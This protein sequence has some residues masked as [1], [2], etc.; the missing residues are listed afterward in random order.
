[1]PDCIIEPVSPAQ[2]AVGRKGV[3]GYKEVLIRNYEL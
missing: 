1:M 2:Y 3:D